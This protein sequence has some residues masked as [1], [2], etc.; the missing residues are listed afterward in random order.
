MD[1]LCPI[2]DA[3]MDPQDMIEYTDYFCAPKVKNHHLS[4]R[5]N[6]KGEQ[7]HLKAFINEH[8]RS[9]IYFKIN[10]V[11]EYTE[12][13]EGSSTRFRIDQVISYDFTDLVSL[14]NKLRTYLVFS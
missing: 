14:R 8:G 12:I 6:D 7:T 9:K 3:K 11:E 10:F 13:W 5:I 2:C 1:Y 4:F